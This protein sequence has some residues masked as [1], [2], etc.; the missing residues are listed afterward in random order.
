[1]HAQFPIQ[2]SSTSSS[3]SF[4][5]SLLVSSL[6]RFWFLGKSWINVLMFFVWISF[7]HIQWLM[8]AVK[9]QIDNYF[10]HISITFFLMNWNEFTFN[11]HINDSR[12]KLIILS[13][14]SWRSHPFTSIDHHDELRTS[15][16]ERERTWKIIIHLPVD[17][18][19]IR[20]HFALDFLFD[21]LYFYS[22]SRSILISF[23]FS[24]FSFCFVQFFFWFVLRVE[25][26]W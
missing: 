12:E 24:F 15:Y 16:G 14:I 23:F 13:W 9:Q 21:F 11:V 8:S 19:F 18:H 5:F 17:T 7:V 3:S 1:M 25:G 22:N 10:G 20:I 2:H 26:T 6:F 4:F